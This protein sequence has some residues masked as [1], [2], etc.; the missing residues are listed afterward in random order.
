MLC[1]SHEAEDVY[2]MVC[3][4]LER[5][6]S[7]LAFA[8]PLSS[9]QRPYLHVLPHANSLESRHPLKSELKGNVEMETL[10]WSEG[11]AG[12]LGGVCFQA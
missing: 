5:L 1:C 11:V 10:R 3:T 7:M 4:R 6:H 12:F 2:M 9:W 8:G